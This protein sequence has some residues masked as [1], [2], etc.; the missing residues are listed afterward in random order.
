V[1]TS[2]RKTE[3]VGAQD[4]GLRPKKVNRKMEKTAQGDS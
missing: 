4:T 1:V 2:E 3:D